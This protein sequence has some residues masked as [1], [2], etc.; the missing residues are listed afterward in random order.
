MYFQLRNA[1]ELF[2]LYAKL[3][4][5]LQDHSSSPTSP[6]LTTSLL[7]LPYPPSVSP[8]PLFPS[9]SSFPCHL[10]SSLPPPLVSCPEG[11]WCHKSKSLQ[12]LGAANQIAAAFIGI[13]RKREQV[14]QWYC[15]KRVIRFIIQHRVICNSTLTITKL[16]HFRKSK[17][18]GL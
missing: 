18:S 1:R 8:P 13:M 15:S 14:L 17:D 5:E 6:P 10:S 3:M 16:Q 4:D 7:P 11:V 9:L 2:C 12:K